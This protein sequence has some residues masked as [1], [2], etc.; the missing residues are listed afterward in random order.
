MEAP[1]HVERHHERGK[2]DMQATSAQIN[3]R[4]DQH[5]KT[6][7]KAKRK[8]KPKE[9]QEKKRKTPWLQ[10]KDP[11][12]TGHQD[13]RREMEEEYERQTRSNE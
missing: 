1:G 11:R 9:I 10:E 7:P 3:W 6:S 4:G 2:D 12:P 5:L 8:C 13:I